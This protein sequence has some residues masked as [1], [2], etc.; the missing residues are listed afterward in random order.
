MRSLLERTSDELKQHLG[1]GIIRLAERHG[2]SRVEV[3]CTRAE[4]LRAA[5]YKTVANIL[6]AGFDELPFDEP[7]ETPTTLPA[8]DN[9]RGAGYYQQEE[10]D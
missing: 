10:E 1:R 4:R 2:S 7:A 9:I 6:A 5:S 8:H 3:A